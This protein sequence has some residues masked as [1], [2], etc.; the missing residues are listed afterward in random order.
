MIV[1]VAVAAMPTTTV[2]VPVTVVTVPMGVVPAVLLTDMSFTMRA[3]L[4]VR[5]VAVVG[6]VQVP[7]E[8]G[9]FVNAA[10][11]ALAGSS[12]AG[13]G[14]REEEGCG[15]ERQNLRNAS[16]MKPPGRFFSLLERFT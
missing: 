7:V 12:Y 11:S 14:R 3:V 9:V 1:R 6:L 16:H 4:S 8:R 10:A 15:A 5:P 13:V 2:T